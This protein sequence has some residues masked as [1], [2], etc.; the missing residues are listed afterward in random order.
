MEAKELDLCYEPFTF[1]DEDGVGII[2]LYDKSCNEKSIQE[3]KEILCDF[4]TNQEIKE[5][6]LILFVTPCSNVLGNLFLFFQDFYFKRRKDL[7]IECAT[8]G[9]KEYIE[10]FNFFDPKK[11]SVEI[12]LAPQG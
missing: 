5:C 8:P 4:C 1:S 9:V 11:D 6:K 2:N 7:K 12:Y 3:I 10:K